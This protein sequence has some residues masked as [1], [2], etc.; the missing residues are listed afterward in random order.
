MGSMGNGGAMR[1]SPIGAYFSDDLPRAAEAARQSAEVTHAHLEGQAGA[2]AVAVAAAWVADGGTRPGEMFEAV[3]AHTPDSET[4]VGVARAAALPLDYDVRTAVSALGNGTRVLSQDTVP[5]ALWC[6]AGRLGSYEEALWR[7]V[8]GLG[9]RD[10]TCAI[11]GGI[12]ILH[13]EAEI[14]EEWLASREPLE[15]LERA[16]LGL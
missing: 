1:A 12:I 8:S 9:D 16:L 13:P 14:P 3:L 7:T 5:F 6:A 10:T 4:R 2:T 15:N 11:A